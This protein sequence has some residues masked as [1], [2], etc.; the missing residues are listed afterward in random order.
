[1]SN[2]RGALQRFYI[3][4][5]DSFIHGHTI[6]E[7]AI[8]TLI[9][10]GKARLGAFAVLVML[11][12]ACQMARMP[13]PETL[14]AAERMPV[15]GRQGLAIR[16]HLRFG[17]YEA[18]Q[19]NRSWTRGRDRGATTV[20]T[21]SERTKSYRFT[22]REDG[23]DRWS[24]AC[25][26]SVLMVTIETRVVDIRPTN[27]SALHCN[28]QSLENRT[29]AWELVLREQWERPLA[30]TLSLGADAYQV[31]GTHRVERAPPTGSTTGYQFR[32]GG[33]LIGA[34]EVIN[35]GAVW[36]RG[37]QSPERRSVLSAAS[38]ALLLLEDLR[39][40]IRD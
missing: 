9:S 2:G 20:A 29:T 33:E 35:R 1:M 15:S 21:Q 27:E 16:Q 14:S 13:L 17:P 5:E 31:I 3:T 30:G 39:E 25:R 6:M 37:D 38:A 23:Q 34:V 4:A 24:V 7:T 18:Y 40:T 32:E 28:I 8:R 11:L 10:S 36:L 12:P 22:L 19:V 26:A